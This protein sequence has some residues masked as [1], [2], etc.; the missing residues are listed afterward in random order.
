MRAPPHPT[1]R[2]PS[3]LSAF[4]ALHVFCFAALHQSPLGQEQTKEKR[5]A[6]NAPGR[7]GRAEG[8]GGGWGR[9]GERRDVMSKGGERAIMRC[10]SR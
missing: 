3:A 10:W 1:V 9:K 4:D 7:V 5:A 2:W 6:A 8:C